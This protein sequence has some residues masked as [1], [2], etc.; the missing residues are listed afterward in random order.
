MVK[1]LFCENHSDLESRPKAFNRRGRKE[2]EENP[3]SRTLAILK[4]KIKDKELVNLES[5]RQKAFNR[6]GRTAPKDELVNAERIQ[7]RSYGPGDG[8]GKEPLTAKG[9]KNAK[10]IREAEPWRY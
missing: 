4:I 7:P 2:R 9:A 3:R 8:P 1:K 5:S 6:R 10:K